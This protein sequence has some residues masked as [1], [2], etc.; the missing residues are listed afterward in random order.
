MRYHD[1]PWHIITYHDISWH[2]MTYHYKSWDIMTY[3]DIS[4]HTL[5]YHD[6]TTC[7]AYL[8]AEYAHFLSLCCHQAWEFCIACRTKPEIS[9]LFTVSKS[10]EYQI[11]NIE[12]RRYWK[13]V[14]FLSFFVWKSC[15]LRPKTH[16]FGS[17]RAPDSL[18]PLFWNNSSKN[19]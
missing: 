16:I 7:R 5:T 14:I 3:H 1:T 2:I 18:F 9:N 15:I 13:I 19:A 10:I 6:M 4:W 17:L 11:L 12:Y 8:L